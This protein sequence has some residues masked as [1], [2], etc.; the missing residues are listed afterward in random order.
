MAKNSDGVMEWRGY[1][2]RNFYRL[3]SF[4]KMI[5]TYRSVQLIVYIFTKPLE[6]YRSNLRSCLLHKFL[7]CVDG[8]NDDDDDGI[9]RRKPASIKQGGKGRAVKLDFAWT[10]FWD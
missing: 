7:A 9:G 1:S 10:H 5:L 8:N 4:S 2:C 6:E 3:F